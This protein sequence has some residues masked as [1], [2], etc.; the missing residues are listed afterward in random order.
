MKHLI[1]LTALAAGLS[2]FSA[3][4][5]ASTTV[6][7]DDAV[8]PV[9]QRW[10]ADYDAAVKVAKEEGKDLLVDF[11][12]SDWCG[13]CIKL[14]EE[15]F[16]HAAFYDEVSKHFVLVAL[17]FPNTPEVQ[18]KVPN[19]ER[20]EALKNQHDIA[21]FPTVLLMNADGEV[22][23]ATGYR[24]GGPEKY[25]AFTAKLTES[26]KALVA[27]A[28]ELPAQYEAADDKAAVVRQAA[29][30][31]AGAVEGAAG[32]DVVSVVV[33][34]GYELDPENESGLKLVALSALIKSGVGDTDDFDLADQL[35]AA[36]ELGLLEVA[37][38]G[39]FGYVDS[40]ET[41]NA[42]VDRVLA[43]AKLGKVHD[44]E[45]L[46]R[47]VFQATFWAHRMLGRPDDSKA[48]LEFART[49]G[50]VPQDLLDALKD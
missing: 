16:Q 30:L 4:A 49:L 27:A 5:L 15:V 29:G 10:F 31:L 34:H 6:Q 42:V 24:E 12:G 37:L 36:N 46:Q 26:G 22:F 45:A 23:G 25:A 33:R 18:A 2:I 41:A 28:K 35:D 8:K 3:V 19:P 44:K 20:N 14:H 17:D 21:G 50:D 43:F 38:A 39:R 32:A 13:W 40:D 11:T 7:D 1:Q 9:E 48:L 47:P